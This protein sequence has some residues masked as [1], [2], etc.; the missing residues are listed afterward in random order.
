[1]VRRPD[2]P[3]RAE[4]QLSRAAMRASTSSGGMINLR[5]PELD[6][7]DPSL[8]IMQSNWAPATQALVTA[9]G[10]AATAVCVAAYARR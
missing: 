7:F 9:A 5:R 6:L 2:D 8:N 3:P 4:F 1:M 10:L